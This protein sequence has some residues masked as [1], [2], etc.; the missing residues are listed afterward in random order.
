M[1]IF[2]NEFC[3]HPFQMELSRYLARRGHLVYHVYFADN[4]STPK[5]Q[6]QRRADDP[7]T[8]TIEGLHITR[9]FAKHSLLTRR[10]SDIEYGE[11]AAAAAERFRPD[12]V[13]SAN[14]PLDAQA[15]LQ[16]TAFGLNARFIFWLQDVYSVAAKF[17]L[18]KKARLLALAGGMYFERLEKKLL[19][20]SD[21]IV[22]IAPGFAEF[23]QNWG[24]SGAKVHVIENWAPLDEVRPLP[25]ANAWA[26][27]H[28]VDQKFCFMY[29]GTLG[30][31]HRPELLLELAKYLQGRGDAS[32]VVIAGGAGAEWLKEKAREVGP[33]VLK[34]LPFQ[35]Y[36]RLSEVMASADTLITLL[37]S[38]AGAF[39][40]PSKTLAYLCAGRPLIIGAPRANEAARV[41]ERAN[42]GIVVSPDDPSEMLQAAQQLLVDRALCARFGV[43]A[44]A[45]AEKTFSIDAIADRFLKVFGCRAP[46]GNL[47]AAAGSS[48]AISQRSH[49]VKARPE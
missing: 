12:V 8:L 35:P 25:K 46:G 34:L 18:R 43:N 29:S 10:Q 9:E 33:D 22:C 28:G 40:V 45:Y 17:V 38:Q 49:P 44:R 30:M 13:I 32:L 4:T 15:I 2:V 26:R 42:A 27:E 41:V 1:R 6:T 37:D 24:I 23:L 20:R 31:K 16:K 47:A 19:R 36:E 7:E 48:P 11:A 21:G 5:G 14:M 3:G 39:A